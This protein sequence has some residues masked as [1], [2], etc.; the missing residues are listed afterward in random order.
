MQERDTKRKNSCHHKQA[1]W[2]KR[3]LSLPVMAKMAHQEVKK[4]LFSS[5]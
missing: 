4:S 2:K 5:K 3:L 1:K